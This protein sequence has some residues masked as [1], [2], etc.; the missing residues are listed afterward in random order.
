MSTKRHDS[1]VYVSRMVVTLSLV[2]VV[3]IALRFDR[4]WNS[5]LSLGLTVPALLVSPTEVAE[6][7]PNEII[8]HW[9]AALVLCFIPALT[10]GKLFIWRRRR[11]RPMEG[12][13]YWRSVMDA[14]MERRR[15]RLALFLILLLYLVALICPILAPHPPD[16]FYQA[17]LGRY[18]PPMSQ[19]TVLHNRAASITPM[20]RNMMR[21]TDQGS[22]IVLLYR[23]NSAIANSTFANLIPVEWYREE[24]DGITASTGDQVVIFPASD[25]LRVQ[26]SFASRRFHVL[27]TDSF[28]RDLLSR[29]L[30]GAR[31]SLV[32]GLVTVL[33]SITLGMLAGLFAGYF[34]RWTD[35]VLM[36]FTDIMLAFPSLFLMLAALALF[37]QLQLP[38]L[39]LIIGVIGMTS[40]MGVA[41]LVRAEVLSLKER[42]FVVAAHTLGLSNARIL[43]R[44]ILPNALAPVI[45]NATLRIGGIIL[46]EAAL[47]F[48]NLG[49]QQPTPSWGNIVLEGKDMLSAAWWI[50]TFPG[51]AIVLTVLAFNIA[52]DGLRD[53][54]DPK[55]RMD[56]SP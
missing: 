11:R 6:G 45:V 23:V 21:I 36:R 29:I 42:E 56:H 54:L 30:F 19:I 31:V 28:G 25:L 5:L 52:G 20:Q 13:S 10:I 16:T 8:E 14:F 49:V 1:R 7:T 48:L 3:L 18:L 2:C 27:G 15:S 41:R 37:E 12:H 35:A 34:G 39:L 55:F 38:R 33:L 40:W 4:V 24:G 9:I 50:T 32:L 26:G 51:I 44:H 17:A 47:S 43:L 53:A 22:L 46:T